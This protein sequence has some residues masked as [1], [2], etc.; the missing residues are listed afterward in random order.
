MKVSGNKNNESSSKNTLV[1]ERKKAEGQ[2]VYDDKEIVAISV[3]GRADDMSV[4]NGTAV[5]VCV[6][7]V[8]DHHQTDLFVRNEQVEDLVI[9][10]PDIS[11]SHVTSLPALSGMY[12]LQFS[13]STLSVSFFLEV[14]GDYATKPSTGGMTFERQFRNN[15]ATFLFLDC[16]H[17]LE[18]MQQLHLEGDVHCEKNWCT[19]HGVRTP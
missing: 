17:R 5:N 6:F 18:A 11:L 2:A 15:G 9:S 12:G 19:V 3:T 10:L 14:N 4:T 8:S 7:N 16:R 13:R 1:P